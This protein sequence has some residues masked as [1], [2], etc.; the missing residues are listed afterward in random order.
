MAQAAGFEFSHLVVN[1]IFNPETGQS[2][3]YEFVVISGPLDDQGQ[4]PETQINTATCRSLPGEIT[5]YGLSV[6]GLPFSNASYLTLQT[7]KIFFE[8]VSL[9]YAQ[10]KQ[11][12]PP[13]FVGLI[14]IAAARKFITADFARDVL[15]ASLSA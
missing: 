9:Y 15:S 10:R 5:L 3:P 13:S 1:N 8:R 12:L 14:E 7:A 2:S 11:K 4:N 6:L